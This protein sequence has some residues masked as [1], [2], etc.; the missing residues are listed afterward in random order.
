MDQK[1]IL[2]KY[3]DNLSLDYQKAY[4]CDRKDPIRTHIF[5]E[6]KKI[7][8]GLIGQQTGRLL[9]IGCG[10]GV[11]TKELLKKNFLIY[12][13]DISPSMIERARQD[14]NE[15]KHKGKVFFKICDIDHLDFENSYFDVVL[16]I[17]V[18]E[19]LQDYHNAIAII[20]KILKRG[21]IAII[22]M[23]NKWS[24]FNI[25]DD[26]LIGIAFKIKPKAF[27]NHESIRHY[28]IKTKK[29]IPSKFARELEKYGLLK[30][31]MKF[32]GY[33][34]AFLRRFFPKFWIFLG[35]ALSR[36]NSFLLINFLANDCVIKFE[37]RA[38]V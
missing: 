32:H 16:C 3:F 20:S 26:L 34:L 17:G 14:L 8:L 38:A 6:R 15:H 36:I 31:S 30:T 12:N 37:K 23:P 35:S 29:L 19:Y 11:M 33:R 10:P 2:K 24:I 21:G 9:D 5:N 4:E 7:V 13:T 18:I 27:N 25:I 22:S 1:D 28:G